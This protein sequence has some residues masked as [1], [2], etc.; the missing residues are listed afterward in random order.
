MLSYT[1]SNKA[2]ED[3]RAIYRYTLVNFG[4]PRAIAYL[5][6]LDECLDL[7]TN[8]P[9]IAQNVDDIRSGYRRYLCREHAIYFIEKRSRLYVIRVLHQQ[10]KAT[11][12]LA[13]L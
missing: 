4:E 6:G 3:L 13:S 7:I 5:T 12:H 11:L 2:E 1:L 10:M 8:T 9:S